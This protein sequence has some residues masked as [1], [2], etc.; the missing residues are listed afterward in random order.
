MRSLF[1]IRIFDRL[2]LMCIVTLFAGV[3]FSY[4]K[5]H[6][7]NQGKSITTVLPVQTMTNAVTNQWYSSLY[8]SPWSDNIFA[9]PLT[10]NVSAKGIGISYPQV[11]ATPNTV[12]A[13]YTQDLLVSVQG[14]ALQKKMLSSDPASVAFAICATNQC[15][16]TR[17][18]HGSPVT[19]FQAATPLT[20]T[21]SATSRTEITPIDRGWEIHFSF[22][23]Y[24]AGI[25]RNHQLIPLILDA[26]QTSWNIPMK[27]S[28]ILVIGLQTKENSLSL[29]EM[30]SEITGTSF[31]YQAND[32]G[33]TTIIHYQTSDGNAPIVALLPHQWQGMTQNPLGT[34]QTLRGA[35]KVYRIGNINEQLAQPSVLSIPQMISSL[36]ENQRQQL[37]NL[38][39]QSADEVSKEQPIVGVYDGGK[40]VFRIA[41]IYQIAQALHNQ[42]SSQ[43]KN[44][45]VSL[46]TPWLAYDPSSNQ[47]YLEV[48]DNPRGIIAKNPQYG[49]EQFNDHHFDYGY[50]LASAGI[51]IQT[52]SSYALRFKPGID[53]LLND[54]AN[55]DVSNGYPYLRGFDPYESHSWADGHG[56]F[57]DGNNQESTSEAI[58][59]WYGIYELGV[60]LKRDDLKILGSMGLT[61]EQ[62]GA[63]IYWLGQNPT[64]YQFPVG[65]NHTFASLI[66]GGKVDF[67]TWFSNKTSNIY[68]IQFLPI[69]PAMTH[70]SNPQAWQKY[71][72][73]QTS[74]DPNAWN[75]IYNMVAVANGKQVSD[76][77]NTYEPG[78]SSPF[79]YLWVSYWSHKNVNQ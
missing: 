74:S 56:L 18:V 57:S 4:Y 63:K 27:E 78:N 43:F 15:L 68:G 12:F 34:Y 38:L 20:M 21:L 62:Q 24:L 14:N 60:G 52:D 13:S 67:A 11:H 66:W 75:D 65:Y 50:Y 6:F 33:I 61:T 47:S 72:E 76:S 46:L 5:S 3:G 32:N 17:L 31:T 30:I 69:T 2:I 64:L 29:N 73:F 41:Q 37:A 26:K 7:P 16:N 53:A 40:Q 58:N 48:S 19:S 59:R 51:L 1:S 8:F 55:T 71:T 42:N 70:I 79:Y 39:N 9:F 49:N 36:T 28:D 77:L 22:G 35:M 45:I 23:S 44:K 54:V 25:I 10:Y